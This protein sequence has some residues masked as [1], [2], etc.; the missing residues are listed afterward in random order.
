MRTIIVGDIHGCYEEFC[1]LLARLRFDESCDKLI[2]LGD[3]MDRGPDSFHVYQK[4]RELS[5]AMGERFVLIRGNHDQMFINASKSRDN[6]FHWY[7]N[8]AKRTVDSFKRN[9]GDIDECRD[10]LLTT[11]LYYET[12]EFICVHAG[13]RNRPMNEQDADTLLWDRQILEEYLYDGKLLIAGHTPLQNALFI[14][15]TG[16]RLELRDGKKLALPKKGYIC[17][18]TACVFGNRLTAM[19]IED[20]MYRLLS[21]EKS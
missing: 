19:I 8:G 18:D 14:S 2:V 12:D 16:L 15:S 5:R 21:I 3:I 6:K 13:A 4:A 11:P 1:L 20:G 10:F 9:H 7:C 17:L